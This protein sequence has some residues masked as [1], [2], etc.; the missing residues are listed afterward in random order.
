[1]ILFLVVLCVLVKSQQC[2]KTKVEVVRE[3]SKQIFES[4]YIPITQN[5][6]CGDPT[7]VRATWFSIHNK[8]PTRLKLSLQF[9]NEHR[10]ERNGTLTVSVLSSCNGK[11]SR[12][13]EHVSTGTQLIMLS[14]VISSN[15]M[16]FVNYYGLIGGKDMK[17]S[18]WVRLTSTPNLTSKQNDEFHV[19]THHL[20]ETLE[21]ANS[22]IQRAQLTLAEVEK[23]QQIN[24]ANFE[25]AKVAHRVMQK[26]MSPMEFVQHEERTLNDSHPKLTQPPTK[27]ELVPRSKIVQINK[28]DVVVQQK[29][30]FTELL[31][32]EL[33]PLSKDLC[34]KR[35][36]ENKAKYFAV[37]IPACKKLR[38]N[39]CNKKTTARVT[40]HIT[41][42]NQ[43]KHVMK[44]KCNY[45]S[46][47]VVMYN[48]K[49]DKPE[50][51]IVRVASD[52]NVGFVFVKIDV[53]DVKKVNTKQGTAFKVV[54]I[55]KQTK[56]KNCTKEMQ[57]SNTNMTTTNTSANVTQNKGSQ[58]K[59]VVLRTKQ[60]DWSKNANGNISEP[61]QSITSSK[62]ITKQNKAKDD[63]Q[64]SVLDR[65]GAKG[66]MICLLV[67]TACGLVVIFGMIIAKFAKKKTGEYTPF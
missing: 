50:S 41:Q 46:G 67:V 62:T 38:V 34:S 30:H 61:K 28:G 4:K 21:K 33:L 27:V 9:Y 1:M 43:C 45:R 36:K 16:V 26:K 7:V 37:E 20:N 18:E 19:N 53:L 48:P 24:R 14:F 11:N 63:K 29:L 10:I 58:V 64:N 23:S 66:I 12:C 51:V 55:E 59:K 57:R 54:T 49:S 22:A 31:S 8:T 42:G 2:T 47:E 25:A 44:Y 15:E 13:I 39:T 32:V 17:E 40:I 3:I 52:N 65:F 35:N 6:G 5:T 60:I 56:C